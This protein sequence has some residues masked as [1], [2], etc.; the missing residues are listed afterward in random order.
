MTASLGVRVYK[1]CPSA[2]PGGH[3]ARAEACETSM[4]EDFLKRDLAVREKEVDSLATY[5]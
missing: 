5:T 3:S 2:D 1:G 4:D